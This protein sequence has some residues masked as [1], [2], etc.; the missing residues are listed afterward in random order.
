[1]LILNPFH[2]LSLSGPIIL[3]LD[4]LDECTEDGVKEVL[5]LIMSNIFHLPLSLKI[6]V[7]SR[8]ESHIADIL[9][10]KNPESAKTGSRV[11]Q[12]VIDP[13]GDE[14]AIRA[15]FKTALSNSEVVR[16]FPAFKEWSIED[17]KIEILVR[18][19]KGL[20]IVA[21]TIVKFILDSAAADPDY[22]L[23]VLLED[24]SAQTQAH[25]EINTLYIRIL[26]H[27]FPTGTGKPILE[28]FRQI[29]GSIV[30]LYEPLSTE[31]LG[32]TS[33]A[34]SSALHRLQSVV[35]V[36]DADDLL[37]PLHPSFIDFLTNQHVCPPSFHIEQ[38]QQHTFLARRCITALNKLFNTSR[39]ITP[40]DITPEVTYA[41][42]HLDEH[43]DSCTPESKIEL[44]VY[45]KSFMNANIGK[46]LVSLFYSGRSSYAIPSIK[47]IHRWLVG[48]Y[49]PIIY[50]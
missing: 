7:T 45:I 32:F 11:Y 28:R 38:S 50:Y 48:F 3:V 1:M 24:P 13:A 20:F 41:L 8:P 29:V 23:S 10:T 30:L 12:H 44:L 19:T 25:S 17:G 16:L 21:A 2:D 40:D 46:W 43:M 31:A 39:E 22:S 42:C 34:V 4:A 36:T 35:A 14:N 9:N 6:F 37:R 47:Q 5:K 49:L 26:Q 27:R 33:Q 18:M 15:F